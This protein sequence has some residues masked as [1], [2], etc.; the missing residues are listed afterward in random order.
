MNGDILIKYMEYLRQEYR[1]KSTR[2]NKIGYARCFLR[3]LEETKGKSYRDLTSQDT[4]DFKA[5]CLEN[6][7]QNG[8]VGRLNALNTF[9]DGFLGK[10]EL[11]VTAPK[12][13]QV[14]KPVLGSKEIKRYVNGATTPL[15]KLIVTYQIDGLLR[16][17]EFSK[18]RISL[19]DESN[20]IIYLD[21]T[22]TGNNS[23][24]F[25]PR[26]IEAYHYYLRYRVRPKH[27]EH[28]DH[29]II[30]DKGSHYGLPLNP[31]RADF[32]WRHTKRIAVKSG[33]KKNVYPYLI[34][35]SAITEGFNNQVNPKILQ[36]QA[37]HTRI[38]TTLRYDH[39][40]DEMAK[41]YYNQIQ[42]RSI[43]DNLSDEDKAKI[44]FDKLIS[45]E[46]DIK[47]FK[48]G[49]DVLLKDHKDKGGDIGYV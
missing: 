25:T 11:R 46:I 30:I 39:S 21:D 22:K 3:W 1:K 29:L 49:L 44:W 15:E 7:K 32:I 24:I 6:Y 18:L 45:N 26:M 4:R 23:V 42:N 13:V 31:I 35:P 40:S 17:G 27:Q 16:P 5:Y 28:D 48:T 47:T 19:H 41:Q 34:K 43:S 37:R 33:F 2:T 36:R 38:E 10:P 14:N 12:S 9:V 8:N 20:Q